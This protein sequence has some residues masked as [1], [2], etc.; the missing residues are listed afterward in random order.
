M[1]NF[2]VP[3]ATVRYLDYQGSNTLEKKVYDL[4][5]QSHVKVIHLFSYLLLT[6]FGISLLFNCLRPLS[7]DVNFLS[8]TALIE[9]VA[10][11]SVDLAG[12]LTSLGGF[13]AVSVQSR[14]TSKVFSR[15]VMGLF[16]IHL[17]YLILAYT[18]NFSQF[19]STMN[20]FLGFNAFLS[21]TSALLLFTV[22]LYIG[23]FFVMKSKQFNSL[24][25]EYI[26]GKN[27]VT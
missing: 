19:N 23:C 10:S 3:T 25:E 6:Y 13:R 17:S 2:S 24:L 4:H 11:I 14:G 22:Y 8:I 21:I 18:I 5:V 1:K 20:Y 7:S 12:V 9:W 26:S 15:A 27:N 16:A